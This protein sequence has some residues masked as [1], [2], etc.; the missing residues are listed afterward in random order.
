MLFLVHL[1]VFLCCFPF[2][3]KFFL[4]FFIRQAHCRFPRSVFCP[5]FYPFP[6]FF[7]FLEFFLVP[8]SND[9]NYGSLTRLCLFALLA[10]PGGKLCAATI[11]HDHELLF[12][13]TISGQTTHTVP[14]FTVP[15]SITRRPYV[16]YCFI[17]NILLL[18]GGDCSKL[19]VSCAQIIISYKLCP[20]NKSGK[21]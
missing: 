18:L 17:S 1:F 5:L 16:P 19:N 2:F 15:H 8:F 6:I 21:K 12:Y 10:V 9:L 7:F 14:Y 11:L 4:V 20:G 13:S 3:F